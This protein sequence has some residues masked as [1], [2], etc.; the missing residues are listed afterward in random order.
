MSR[1]AGYRYLHE[2]IAALAWQAPTRGARCSRRRPPAGIAALS[3]ENPKGRYSA[4]V[5]A[6]Q[7]PSSAARLTVSRPGLATN[8]GTN[9]S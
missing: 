9:G 4:T 3:D 2:G 5:A 7:E 8:V 1:S 6:R